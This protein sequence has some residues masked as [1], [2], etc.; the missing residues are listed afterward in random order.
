[1]IT[2][3]GFLGGLGLLVPLVARVADAQP[4]SRFWSVGFL[5]F[6][7]RRSALETGRYDA[8]LEGMRDLGYAEG[9]NLSVEGRF[10]NG[11]TGRLRGLA[12]E[13][14]RLKVD[15]IVATGTPAVRAAH[16]ATSTVPIVMTVA[17]D[18]V[19][20]GF[21]ASLARPGGNITGLSVLS[22]EVTQKYP[23]LLSAAIPRLSRV[24][25]LVNPSNASHPARRKS[26]QVTASQFGQQVLAIEAR[27]VADIERGFGTMARDGAGAVVVFGDTFFVQKARR[28]VELALKHRVP[29]LG[30]TRE[31]AEVGG[32]MSYSGEIR[33]NFRRAA[34][35]VD[36]IVKGAKAG[37]LPIEQPTKFEMVINL[38][39]ARALGI[40][41]PQSLLDRA[42]LIK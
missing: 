4:A 36:R 2:R 6:G 3:R 21:A 22:E 37:D 9:K 15:V 11:K 40:T 35:Y 29:S 39:T 24:A 38:R 19:L 23:E 30:P 8:F 26:I 41:I 34:T 25:V 1:V 12:A 16:Q 28:I 31:F 18:P 10:A 20:D 14:V 7:S 5:Y 33:D 13:L 27:T 32:F 17:G 42:D